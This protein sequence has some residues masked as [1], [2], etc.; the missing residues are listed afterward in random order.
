MDTTNG[1]LQLWFEYTSGILVHSEENLFNYE[2]AS[3]SNW[4]NHSIVRNLIVDEAPNDDDSDGDIEEHI[5]DP[6][7]IG[8]IIVIIISVIGGIAVY[9]SFAIKTRKRTRID[10]KFQPQDVHKKKRNPIK[11]SSKPL[12]HNPKIN[13]KKN[14]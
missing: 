4:Y 9:L 10:D 12:K 13:A 14:D 5:D 3:P 7:I 11:T 1:T 2:A 6:F 8:T